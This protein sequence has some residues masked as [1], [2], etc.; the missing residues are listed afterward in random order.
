L[1]SRDQR[2]KEIEE[3]AQKL[4]ELKTQREK[5]TE[6]TRDWA[7]KRDKTNERV[8]ELRAEIAKVRD[9][10]DKL[11][12][13]VQDF[14][15]QRNALREKIRERIK[16]IKELRQK[17]EVVSEKKPLRS[18]QSLQ[19]E[20]ESIDWEI[21]TSLLTPQ[22]E[23]ELVEQVKQL[24]TQLGIHKK[25]EH[26]VQ[27]IHE[28]QAEIRAIDAKGKLFHEKLTAIA[29]KSQELHKKM[30]DKIEE[31][32]KLK[33]EA[34]S[35]YQ[36]FLQAKEKTLLVQAEISKVLNQLKQAKG[37]IREEEEQEKRKSEESLREK[38]QAEA[39]EKLKRG[40]KLT[41]EEF[42]LLNE[43][44]NNAEED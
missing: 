9:E 24:E 43:D 19:K 23:K 13:Q 14:K 36:L 7:D 44:E 10:R 32:K 21:Q 42:K 25:Y 12:E 33:T 18:H 15:L 4:S 22:E 17:R 31:S 27:K 11:N 6:E 35:L 41:L 38:L 20:V 8:K 1:L 26:L 40:D 30:I 34:D 39:R 3:L 28:L 2:K 37:E 29:Q 5:L 16:E